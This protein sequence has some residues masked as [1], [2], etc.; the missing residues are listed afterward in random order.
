MC[1]FEFGAFDNT[2]LRIFP[3]D[4]INAQNG[5]ARSDW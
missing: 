1:R 5:R 2:K 4:L 3:G